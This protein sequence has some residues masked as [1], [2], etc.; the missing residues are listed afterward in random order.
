MFGKRL[1]FNREAHET[2]AGQGQAIATGLY[3]WAV[4]E[5]G[6]GKR[7]TGKVLILQSIREGF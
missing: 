5:K 3:I 7:Q 4:Q 1:T 2:D 6:T